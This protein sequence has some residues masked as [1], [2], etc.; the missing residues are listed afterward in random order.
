MDK[1]RLGPSPSGLV[2]KKDIEGAR[3]N[4]R[5]HA[6][7]GVGNKQGDVLV[8]GLICQRQV[9]S[10]RPDRERKAGIGVRGL[11]RYL[12]AVRHGVARIDEQVQQRVLKLVR[13][14]QGQPKLGRQLDLNPDAGSLRGAEQLFHGAD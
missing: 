8:G 12:S 6:L 10:G 3:D 2:V 4:V 13:I 1:P 7:V 11:D 9:F 14:A 5:C